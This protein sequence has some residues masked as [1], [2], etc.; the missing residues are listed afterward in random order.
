[1]LS[2]ELHTELLPAPHVRVGNGLMEQPV[3]S[4]HTFSRETETQATCRSHEDLFGEIDAE[5]IDFYDEP[6]HV[7]WTSVS[8]SQGG[9]GSISLKPFIFSQ[10]SSFTR[11]GTTVNK[12]PTSP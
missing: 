10:P 6:P 1:M 4:G 3:S 9:V 12:S 8:V 7:R 11:S 2:P 5:N